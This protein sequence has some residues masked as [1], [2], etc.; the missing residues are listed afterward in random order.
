MSFSSEV[1]KE[2]CNRHEG[3]R[4]CI[5]AEL[6]AILNTCGKITVRNGALS[7]VIQTENAFVAKRYFTLIKASFSVNGNVAVSKNIALKKNRVY[8]V[9]IHDNE[10]AERLL[11]AVSLVKKGSDGKY[12]VKR[13]I[14]PLLVKDTCCKRAYIRGAFIAGGS[15]NTPEK[16]YHMEFVNASEKLSNGLCELIN[17]FSL[18]AKVI[19]RK[20]H[21]VVYLKEGESIVDLLNVMEAPI[22]LMGLE[23]VRILKDMR[24]DINR[25]VNCET[26]NINKTVGAAVKQIDD[27]KLIFEKKGET[28]LSEQLLEVA[29]LRLENPDASLKELGE[30]VTPTIGK[31]GINHRFRKISEIAD[32]LR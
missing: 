16:T 13:T 15:L 1:K 17:F 21:F 24:N 25:R 5:I 26:A 31:S 7:V 14:D 22:S 23:N 12:T 18:H 19:E 28:F 2:L 27:I 3:A 29:L 9:S 4:H 8:T 10:S 32:V 11:S 30:M 20:G 6:C